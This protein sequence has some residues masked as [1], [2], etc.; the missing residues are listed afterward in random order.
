M[1]N[2]LIRIASFIA[3]A[4]AF[5]LLGGYGDRFAWGQQV[6]LVIAAFALFQVL[7]IPRWPRSE[8]LRQALRLKKGQKIEAEGR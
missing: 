4:E 1:K 2:S 6:L 7:F 8:A 5:T 3:V